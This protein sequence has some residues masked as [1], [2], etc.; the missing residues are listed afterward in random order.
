[1]KFGI[2]YILTILSWNIVMDDWNLDEFHLVS[3]NNFNIVNLYV[4]IRRKKKKKREAR[5][6]K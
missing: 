4:E 2:F 1:M 3:D 6:D 5:N